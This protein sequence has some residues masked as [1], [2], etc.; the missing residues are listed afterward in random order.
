MAMTV[1]WY[2]ENRDWCQA[3]QRKGGYQGERLSRRAAEPVA[4]ARPRSTKK[5]SWL[6]AKAP[7]FTPPRF[8]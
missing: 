4:T 7:G 5:L 2:L 6:E 3:V 1:Q 8:A